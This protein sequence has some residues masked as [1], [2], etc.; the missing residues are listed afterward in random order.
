LRGHFPEVAR[1]VTPLDTF[2]SPWL[3]PEQRAHSDRRAAD[4]R[5]SGQS[6]AIERRESSARRSGIDRRETPDAHV[7]NALQILQDLAEQISLEGEPKEKLDGA[8][9]RLW[10]ALAEVERQRQQ[11]HAATLR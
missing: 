3:P 8:V 1:P 11:V 5:L 10:L 6:V 9:R 4:R 7:R 2:R